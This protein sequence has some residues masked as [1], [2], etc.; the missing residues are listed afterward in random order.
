M[1]KA[2]RWRVNR[3]ALK[4][5]LILWNQIRLHASL[6]LH[7]SNLVDHRALRLIYQPPFLPV[8]GP[9]ATKADTSRRA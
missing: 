8:L 9:R 6:L 3:Y 7:R 5:S 2:R 4:H 1:R